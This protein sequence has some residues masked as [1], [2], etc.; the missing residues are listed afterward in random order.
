MRVAVI[1]ATPDERALV[2][3]VL[4][5]LGAEVWS[6]R[7][8]EAGTLWSDPARWWEDVDA[9][10]A[11]FT[12]SRRGRENVLIELGIALGR[13]LPLLLLQ[14]DEPA[15]LP[16][17]LA[18]VSSA[19]TNL[20]NAEALRFHLELFLRR[21]SAGTAVKPPPPEAHRIDVE[22]VRRSLDELRRSGASGHD[23][24]RWVAGL[25]RAAG[26]D[27]VESRSPEARGFD[28]AVALSGVSPEPGPLL[29]EVKVPAARLDLAAAASQLQELVLRERAG[30]GLLLFE[31]WRPPE[32]GLGLRT[33][34]VVA[35]AFDELLLRLERHD[36]SLSRA[37]RTA[38]NE[39]VHGL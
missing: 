8:I 9:V 11:V 22:N 3:E 17:D 7:V 20:Q 4:D 27:L 12:G 13:G 18:E 6:P 19:R 36:G 16:L 30:L 15:P 34:M 26:A 39:A 21:V 33:L 31:G 23:Y 5:D 29:V 24:E 2:L 25:F 35:M 1:G 10:V 28:L 38:R 37:L 32:Y 14:G